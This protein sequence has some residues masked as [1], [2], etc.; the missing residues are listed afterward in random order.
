M[1]NVIYDDQYGGSFEAVGNILALLGQREKIRQ[2]RELTTELI[3][4]LSKNDENAL[5]TA[6]ARVAEYQPS[7]RGGIGGILQSI[8]QRTM[9]GDPRTEA[10]AEVGLPLSQELRL[11]QSRSSGQIG[12]P[13]QLMETAAIATSVKNNPNSK[14]E[15]VAQAN[16]ILSAV[17][18]ALNNAFQSYGAGGSPGAAAAGTPKRVDTVNLRTGEQ[19]RNGQP[20]GV[21][22]PGYPGPSAAAQSQTAGAKAAMT[23]PQSAALSAGAPSK[24]IRVQ[25]PDGQVGTI[26]ASELNAAVQAGWKKLQ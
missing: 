8:G 7:Q 1:A 13:N 21:M 10:L 3:S 24:R 5:N 15:D 25:S 6:L 16:Q 14:P 12:T 17:Y 23:K 19:Y 11:G 26:D 18:P 9:Q 4:A 20:T 2:K 22:D